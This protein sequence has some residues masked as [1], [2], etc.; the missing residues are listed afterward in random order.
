MPIMTAYSP[1]AEAKI[2]TI[3][4]LINVEPFYEVT[5]AVL[6]PSTPT[7]TPQKMFERPT[8]IPTQKAAYPAFSAY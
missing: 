5:R 8:V 6:E 7:H 1:I 4:M 3:S 2:M